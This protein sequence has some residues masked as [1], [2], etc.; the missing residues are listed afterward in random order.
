V[1]I[2]K[3]REIPQN[4]LFSDIIFK[5]WKKVINIFGKTKFT[6]QNKFIATKLRK[7]KGMNE[8]IECL[9]GPSGKD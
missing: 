7:T 5:N 8:F 2:T 4:L 6:F 3:F 1:K 9:K